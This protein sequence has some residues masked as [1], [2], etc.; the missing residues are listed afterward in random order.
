MKKTITVWRVI[1][2]AIFVAGAYA[3]YVRFVKGPSAASASQPADLQPPLPCTCWAWNA[4]GRSYG[5]R[6]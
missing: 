6:S 4:I 1:L 2:I 3:T 5:R